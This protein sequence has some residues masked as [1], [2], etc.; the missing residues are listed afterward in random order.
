ME[1]RELGAHPADREDVAA[2]VAACSPDS[3]RAR[4]LMGGP[5][6]PGEV[7]RRYRRFLLA[8]SPAL[9]AARDG[10]P[11][12]LLNFVTATPG[13]AEVG[14]LVADAGQRQGIGS[15]LARWLRA[16][17]RWPGWTVRAT[18]RAG[19]AGAEACCCARDS[20]RCPPTSAANGTSRWS[21]PPGLP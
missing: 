13:E 4:F 2:L 19:N 15:A 6:E 9:P 20:G 3:L 18:V 17:G 14:I 5:A 11:A 8:G 7:F 1:I 16:S 12:G 21:S 10:A